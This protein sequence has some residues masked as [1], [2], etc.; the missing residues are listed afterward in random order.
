MSLLTPALHKAIYR[1]QLTKCA[2]NLKNIST[3]II[4][5]ADDFNDIYPSNGMWRTVHYDARGHSTI[6]D[7]LAPYFGGG[8]DPKTISMKSEVFLCPLYDPDE[9]VI[10]PW[11]PPSGYA[12]GKNHTKISYNLMFSNYYPEREQPYHLWE[13]AQISYD[14]IVPHWHNGRHNPLSIEERNKMMPRLGD[15]WEAPKSGRRFNVLAS[16]IIGGANFGMTSNHRPPGNT[17]Y[18]QGTTNPNGHTCDY[19]PINRAAPNTANYAFD[20][21]SVVFEEWI[22]QRSSEMDTGFSYIYV[23]IEWGK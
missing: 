15:T 7:I 19:G 11:T 6:Q 22:Y 8:N 14:C 18:L 13:P 17:D 23:P 5:Y 16:D 1:A 4:M 10:N 20:D 2:K 3:G 9:K 12:P 21:G